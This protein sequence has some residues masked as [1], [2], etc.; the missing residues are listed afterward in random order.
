MIHTKTSK[1]EE[2]CEEEE[3]TDILTVKQLYFIVQELA[4]KNKKLE[5]KMEDMLKWIDKKKKKIDIVSWLNINIPP[6][7]IADM[8]ST[9]IHSL[10]IQ[11]DDVTMLLTENF[12]VT[13]NNILK[14]NLKSGGDGNNPIVAFDTHAFYIC[15]RRQ[16]SDT[17]SNTKTWIKMTADDFT[18]LVGAI[19]SKLLKEIC[20]WRQKNQEKMLK[21]EKMEESFNRMIVKFMGASPTSTDVNQ[22]KIKHYLHT[23][24]KRDLN[25]VEYEFSGV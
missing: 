19:H 3:N 5:E 10:T 24:V 12:T 20:S 13:A 11:E 2:T 25:V 9:W 7:S 16:S 15:D 14:N 18:R 6:D 4:I 17:P 1:R 21:N 22:D 23:L 8:F